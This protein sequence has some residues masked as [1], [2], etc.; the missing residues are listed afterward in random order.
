MLKIP[1]KT[2]LSPGQQKAE[3]DYFVHISVNDVLHCYIF[4]SVE[5]KI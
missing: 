4:F 2:D 3:N 1:L 5:F